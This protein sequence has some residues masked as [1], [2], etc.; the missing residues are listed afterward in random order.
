MN[1]RTRIKLDLI[2]QGE[3]DARAAH[4][5]AKLITEDMHRND[6]SQVIAEVIKKTRAGTIKD[7]KQQ[8]VTEVTRILEQA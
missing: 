3:M 8:V 2:L 4:N 5:I 7:I 1:K 6:V